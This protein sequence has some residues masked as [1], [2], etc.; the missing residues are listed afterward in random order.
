MADQLPLPLLLYVEDEAIVSMAIIIALEEAGF[1][2]EHVVS[3][4]KAML[5]LDAR[6]AE[7]QA[8]VTDIR[9]PEVDG[10]EIARR[11][12]EINGAVPVVYV[13]GDSARGWS[14]NGVP[15]S[16]M[17][18]KPFANAQVVAAITTLLN[19]GA[20]SQAAPIRACAATAR[21]SHCARVSRA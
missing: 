21:G 19:Q 5:A 9:L 4:D 13:S 7:Y 14:V 6:G 18:Q 15:N 1:D 10:W 12:R 3:G 2:V 17:V 8:L 16:I 20:T 11:A